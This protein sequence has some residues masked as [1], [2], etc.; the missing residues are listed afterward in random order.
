MTAVK[1]VGYAVWDRA[2]AR[3]LSA[4][5]NTAAGACDQREWMIDSG[6]IRRTLTEILPVYWCPEHDVEVLPDLPECP[7]CSTEVGLA[8]ECR[9]LRGQLQERDARIAELEEERVH[10]C[11]V[12]E[13][14]KVAHNE[15][16]RRLEPSMCDLGLCDCGADNEKGDND[17]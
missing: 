2:E 17:E 8:E 16:R 1:V 10:L 6:E 11:R 13:L 3:Y 12:I 5:A 14:E 15:T 4:R 9:R 7:A